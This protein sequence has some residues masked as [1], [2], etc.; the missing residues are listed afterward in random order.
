MLTVGD[1]IHY[2]PTLDLGAIKRPSGLYIVTV[3]ESDH[4]RAMKPNSDC[5][6]LLTSYQLSIFIH[7]GQIEV[8]SKGDKKCP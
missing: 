4:I 5:F 7:E 2:Q 8:I 1:I 3:A 6:L